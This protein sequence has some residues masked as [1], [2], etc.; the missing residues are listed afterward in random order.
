MYI[1][2]LSF[3]G[4]HGGKKSKFFIVLG[5]V[6]MTVKTLDFEL[7]L[8][9]APDSELSETFADSAACLFLYVILSLNYIF[10]CGPSVFVYLSFMMLFVSFY[11]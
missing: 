5:A 10:Q 6:H 1:L 11:L 3:N 9:P 7:Y 4:I 2:F 8:V